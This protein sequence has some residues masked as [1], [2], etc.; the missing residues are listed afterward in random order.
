M[1][2]GES[3]SCYNISR[4]TV[5]ALIRPAFLL[6]GAVVVVVGGGAEVRVCGSAVASC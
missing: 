4:R 5:G 2:E 1:A 3:A 6:T